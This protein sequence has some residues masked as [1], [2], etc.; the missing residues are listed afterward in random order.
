M[1]TATFNYRVVTYRIDCLK[2]MGEFDIEMEIGNS[3][4]YKD[5]YI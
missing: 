3:Y 2:S 4:I 5:M 1:S